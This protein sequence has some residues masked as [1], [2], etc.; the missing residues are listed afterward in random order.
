MTAEMTLLLRQI[1]A[2]VAVIPKDRTSQAAVQNSVFSMTCQA[3]W[4]DY[5]SNSLLTENILFIKQRRTDSCEPTGVMDP[6]QSKQG[7]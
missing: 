1:N 3:K 7:F 2:E 4:K 5:F 6:G